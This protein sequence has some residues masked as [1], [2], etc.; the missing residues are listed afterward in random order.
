MRHL[1]TGRKLNRNASHRK[2]LFRNMAASLLRHESIKTTGPKALEL[3]R[4]ADR[5]IGLAKENSA[6]AIRLAFAYL[7]DK[8]VVKSFSPISARDTLT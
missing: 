5:L 7:R 1:N 6:H 2:A 3:R 8:D 4:A